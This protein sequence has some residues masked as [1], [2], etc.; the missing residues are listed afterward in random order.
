MEA[1]VGQF[2]GE[3]ERQDKERAAAR[4]GLYVHA[5]KFGAVMLLLLAINLLTSPAYLWFVW[6]LLG[7]GI[8]LASHAANVLGA[9]WRERRLA[10]LL[11][12]QRRERWASRP[13]D[14]GEQ[15][16]PDLG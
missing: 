16:W 1:M 3:R 13:A 7:W 8:G 10:A 6:P 11:S 12:R 15:V 4:L 14:D 5:G 9:E 2:D